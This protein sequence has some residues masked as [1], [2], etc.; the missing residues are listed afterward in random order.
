MRLRYCS[1]VPLD[2]S[3]L[4]PDSSDS[5]EVL[6]ETIQP[7]WCVVLYLC[8]L[9]SR[10]GVLRN[11]GSQKPIRLFLNH[12]SRYCFAT[13]GFFYCVRAMKHCVTCFFSKLYI[14][15]LLFRF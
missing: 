11:I 10:V 8:D 12:T 7:F 13:E 3:Q 4:D 2:I 9:F 6:Q 1:D 5:G 15:P 14:T